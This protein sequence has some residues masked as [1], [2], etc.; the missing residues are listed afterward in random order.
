M[1][2]SFKNLNH[3]CECLE[4]ENAMKVIM[5]KWWTESEGKIDHDVIGY[6]DNRE[7]YCCELTPSVFVWV[8]EFDYDGYFRSKDLKVV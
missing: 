5:P 3:F 8:P 2:E 6:T 7:T 1:T 4:I